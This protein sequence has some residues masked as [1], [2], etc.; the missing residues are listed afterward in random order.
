MEIG[1]V[2]A[3]VFNARN[4]SLYLSIHKWVVYL[5]DVLVTSYSI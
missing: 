4:L 3:Y 1:K 2:L 5:S